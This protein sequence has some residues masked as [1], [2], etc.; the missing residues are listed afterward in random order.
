MCAIMIKVATL[1][2]GISYNILGL[3]LYTVGRVYTLYRVLP[4]IVVLPVTEVQVGIG[5][6]N[7]GCWYMHMHIHMWN[8][9]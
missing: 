5:T 3:N 4:L 8:I 1:N 2:L 6:T 9:L 7:E